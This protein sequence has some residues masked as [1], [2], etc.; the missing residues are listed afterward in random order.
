MDR[1]WSGPAP[2]RPGL[3]APP[4]EPAVP[5]L[6]IANVLTMA[7]IALV[8]L[9]VLALFA[10]GG[11]D[12]AWRVTAAALFGLAAITDRFDGQL[13]RKYGLVT[14]FGKLA[15]PIA[16]KALIGSALIGLSVLGDLAWWITIVICGRELGV[17]LLRL[18]VVRR[19]VIPAGR[20]GKLKTLVQSLAIAVLVLPLAGGFATAGMAL[21]WVALVL[22]VATGLDYV[23]QAARV[24]F[25]GSARNRAA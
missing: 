1:G 10:G 25:A 18:V 21:M 11:H 6:N 5:L 17:T 16:D 7:R 20:G 22:T 9:F 8:P 2:L 24:W 13:A 23:G 15:D 14:D 19:G 3:V 12:T 4:A